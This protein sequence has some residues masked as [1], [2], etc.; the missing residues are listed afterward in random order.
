MIRKLR[1]RGAPFKGV[2]YAGLMF[3]KDGPGVL[4]YNVRFGDP[5]CQPLLMRLDGDLAEIMMACVNGTLDKVVVKPRP[6]TC[7]CV[8][9]AAEGYPGSY[10]KGME[11]TGIEEAEALEG[12]KVFHAGTRLS[13]GKVTTS[14][15]RIL[16]VTAL[17]ADLA[18]AKARAYQAVEKIH[19]DHCYF[20]RDIGDKGLNR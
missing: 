15:G 18:D 16:G 17:G 8:V 14:G 3:T 9:L 1:E 4:E 20:R 11:I 5:E 10:P 12:V 19:F 13:E 6:E 7:I 2:L